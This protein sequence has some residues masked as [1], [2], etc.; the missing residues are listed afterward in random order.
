M[1]NFRLIQTERLCRRQFQIWRKWKKVIQTGRK[2]CGKRRNACYKG[3]RWPFRSWDKNFTKTLKNH[4]YTAKAF[5]FSFIKPQYWKTFWQQ[6]K[7]EIYQG[8]GRHR[9]E[10][11]SIFTWAARSFTYQKYTDE[12]SNIASDEDILGNNCIFVMLWNLNAL[13]IKY[14][15][16][17]FLFFLFLAQNLIT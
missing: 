5:W 3:F 2:H 13:V 7:L 6:E 16:N 14:S 9:R 1:T 4:P 15:H 11:R 17:A 8:P 10:T 12:A